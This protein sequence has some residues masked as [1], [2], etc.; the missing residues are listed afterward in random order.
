MSSSRS[1]LKRDRL[2]HRLGLE[3]HHRLTI[4]RHETWYRRAAILLLAIAVGAG[5]LFA[6]QAFD[7]YQHPKDIQLVQL[8]DKVTELTAE[9]DRLNSAAGTGPNAVLMAQTAQQ[10][11]AQQLEKAQADAAKLRE[12]LSFCQK[13]ATR[14]SGVRKAPI[15]IPGAGT[16][17]AGSSPN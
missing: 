13:N 15:Q 12:E 1:A 9:I 4:R 6:Y 2:R 14:E 17:P 8:R 7:R 5:L 3:T 10:T 11:L 16:I